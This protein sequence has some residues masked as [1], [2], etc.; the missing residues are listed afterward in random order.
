MTVLAPRRFPDSVVRRRQG[1]GSYNQFG[2]FEPGTVE[3][4]QMAASVQP[5]KLEDADAAGGVSVSHRL[6]VYVPEPGALAAALDTAQADT[7]LVDGL[8]YVVEESQSWRASHTRAILL[9]QT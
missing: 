2:E 4:T 1:P 6:S 7:V 3:E 9:R 8:E 5:L